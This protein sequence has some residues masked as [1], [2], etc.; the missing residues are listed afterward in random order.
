MIC[1]M[2]DKISKSRANGSGTEDHRDALNQKFSKIKEGPIQQASTRRCEMNQNEY[3][4]PSKAL[5]H[6]TIIAERITF[7][8]SP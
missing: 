5:D 4:Q 1:S 6:E 8:L 3:R 2:K 7:I